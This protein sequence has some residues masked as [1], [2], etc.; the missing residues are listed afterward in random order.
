MPKNDFRLS[1]TNYLLNH[2]VGR[3]LKT[4]QTAFA[5]S[6]FAPWQDSGIEPWGDWLNIIDDFRSA[7]GKMF[8]A[9]KHEFCPQVNL[10]S[11][12][13]KI[14]MSLAQLQQ[15]K[16]VVLLSEN[17]FPSI[18]FALQKALPEHYQ[19]KFIPK[20]QDI[21]D[22]NVW[23]AYLT[24]DVD[25]AFISHAYSNTGEIAP[26]DE[27]LKLTKKCNILSILDIAQSA[28]IVPLDLQKQCPDF[29]I[30][31]SV[32]WLCGGPGAA[33]LWVNPDKIQTCQPKD[34][35]WFSH[36]N[37]F[38]FD[39]HHFRYHDTALKF[40]GGTPSIA[41]YSIA[42]HSIEY[43]SA[44]GSQ[45]MRQHNQSLIELVAAQ[46]DKEFVSPREKSKR[47]G[48]LILN[49]GDKQTKVMTA[50]KNANISVDA[51]S[52]GMRISP[53]IYNDIEDIEQLIAVIKSAS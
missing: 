49:F 42:A 23:Q 1:G 48:T 28:G 10:S 16:P 20:E 8:N 9:S 32:K 22:I 19:L 46:F 35:G 52:S 39:I 25:L 7:L 17:D 40:W 31:S 24:Q 2:S 29:M 14:V 13:T 11:A 6:F 27:I 47:S 43:F 34:V 21:T 41:P 36:E 44:L 38:E 53:H 51:R 18:G 15:T 50:L 30:G 33:Y 45:A 26:L 4:A 3:P 37:P 12:L 5:E